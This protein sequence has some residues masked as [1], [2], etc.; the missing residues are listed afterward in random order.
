MVKLFVALMILVLPAVSL[1]QGD[2]PDAR[3]YNNP[4]DVFIFRADVCPG[5]SSGCGT[6]GGVATNV[7]TAGNGGVRGFVS[8]RV[9]LT[10]PY[11]V[12]FLAPDIDGAMGPAAIVSQVTAV[13]TAGDTASV[14]AP[15]PSL[16]SGV[17]RFTA[18]VAGA[19]GRAAISHGYQFRYCNV[20]CVAE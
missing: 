16:A 12:Y 9:P 15:F 1:A 13:L 4:A 3:G 8:F 17:Y 11:T 5:N 2:G 10:Q 14:T 18:L 7:I 6:T 19:N 20:A